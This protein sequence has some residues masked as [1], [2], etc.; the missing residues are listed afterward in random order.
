MSVELSASG[1]AW[2]ANG[3]RTQVHYSNALA[4]GTSTLQRSYQTAAGTTWPSM[5][6]CPISPVAAGHC[7]EL[8]ACCFH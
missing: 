2:D 8:Q 7:M 1:Y 4:S 3:N 5:A 6:P